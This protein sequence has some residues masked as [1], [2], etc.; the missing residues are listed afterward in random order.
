VSFEVPD[1]LRMR[2][3]RLERVGTPPLP[4][5]QGM[6]RFVWDLSHAGPWSAPRGGGRGGG[7]GG[8]GGGEKAG[9]IGSV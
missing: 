3:W 1:E 2:E 4:A 6:N 8:G 9:C 5:E 7:G